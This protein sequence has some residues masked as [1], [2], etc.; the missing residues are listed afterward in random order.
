MGV[1]TEEFKMTFRYIMII[2]YTTTHWSHTQLYHALTMISDKDF[3]RSSHQSKVHQCLCYGDIRVL[4]VYDRLQ[5]FFTWYYL[6]QWNKL[7][8][9]LKA[10]TNLHRSSSMWLYSS[11]Q[12]KLYWQIDG[13]RTLTKNVSV[14]IHL[15][16]HTRIQTMYVCTY[17]IYIAYMYLCVCAH[18]FS[19]I[20]SLYLH[21]NSA[22]IRGDGF[23]L[24]VSYSEQFQFRFHLKVLSNLF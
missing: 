10:K 7:N 23:C 12:I 6:D 22:K 16:S 18:I 9:F 21:R 13:V 19:K 4:I 11:I 1:Y 3:S 2:Y 24:F 14:Y 5:M 15:N 8:K 17:F 20:L